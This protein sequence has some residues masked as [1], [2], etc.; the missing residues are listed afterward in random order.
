MLNQAY[1]AVRQLQEKKSSLHKISDL[2]QLLLE[3][4]LSLEVEVSSFSAWSFLWNFSEE[5][6]S[7]VLDIQLK[8]R[9]LDSAGNILEPRHSRSFR[10]QEGSIAKEALK[11]KLLAC[12]VGELQNLKI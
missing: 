8:P 4:N 12:I 9:L 5:E 7:G 3:L 10:I 1:N 11:E 6:L 2:R